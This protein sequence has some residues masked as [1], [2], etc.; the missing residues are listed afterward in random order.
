MEKLEDVMEPPSL[1]P[2]ADGGA[3]VI[4]STEAANSSKDWWKN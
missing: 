2:S 1:V 4:M 3:P